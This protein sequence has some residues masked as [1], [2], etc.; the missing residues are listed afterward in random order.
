MKGKEIAPINKDLWNRR[1]KR[2]KL[3]G[4]KIRDK[5]NKL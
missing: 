1:G 2:R 5:T 3:K 4:K